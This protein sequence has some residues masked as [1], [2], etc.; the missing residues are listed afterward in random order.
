MTGAGTLGVLLGR[1][2]P[3]VWSISP[4]AT[5]MT[6]QSESPSAITSDCL[7]AAFQVVAGLNQRQTATFLGIKPSRLEWAGKGGII[8]RDK[9]GFYPC[10]TV[11]AQWF[12]LRARLTRQ[13]KKAQPI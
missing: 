8:K 13:G 3:A 12:G 11:K 1:K 6:T 10:E 5:M 4:N 7:Q 2:N 9:E